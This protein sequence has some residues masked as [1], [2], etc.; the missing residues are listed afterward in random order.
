MDEDDDFDDEM[1]LMLALELALDE[2]EDSIRSD[3]G[4]CVGT[5]KCLWR[6]IFYAI[7]VSPSPS[8][9]RAHFWMT[10]DSFNMLLNYCLEYQ[11]PGIRDA[12]E[13]LAVTLE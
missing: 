10:K 7:Y 2:S 6:A 1:M 13:A 9:F 8:L 3:P 5:H 11:P 4:A 12:R